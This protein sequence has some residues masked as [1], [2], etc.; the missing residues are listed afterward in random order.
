MTNR[1]GDEMGVDVP[2]F[3]ML[4][5]NPA[6]IFPQYWPNSKWRQVLEFI[7]TFLHLHYPPMPL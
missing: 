1:T 5:S 3:S 6:L 7:G 4:R 2:V